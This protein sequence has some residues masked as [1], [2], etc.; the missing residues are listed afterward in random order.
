VLFRLQAPAEDPSAYHCLAD[1]LQD[2]G[3][4]S[5]ILP[6]GRFKLAD[7]ALLTNCDE[8]ELSCGSSAV[9]AGCFVPVELV[10]VSQNSSASFLFDPRAC[11][12]YGAGACAMFMA[13]VRAPVRDDRTDEVA[14]DHVQVGEDCR[15][16]LEDLLS[17]SPDARSTSLEAK[18]R[19]EELSGEER[20]AMSPPFSSPPSPAATPP[21]MLASPTPSPSSI[22]TCP[23][24]PKRLRSTYFLGA[25]A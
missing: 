6:C 1:P 4:W 8:P 21:R 13:S 25:S 16:L 11:D 5:D 23:S 17:P 9:A 18:A 22:V 3:K 24:T 15:A 19:V 14:L 7:L 10:R 12:V 20:I 2:F